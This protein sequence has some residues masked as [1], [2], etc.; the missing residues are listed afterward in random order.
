V[1]ELLR[2]ELGIDPGERLTALHRNILHTELATGRALAGAQVGRP[3]P[4]EEPPPATGHPDTDN[5][6][7]ENWRHLCQ[8]P[9]NVTTFVGRGRLMGEIAAVMTAG[10]RTVPVATL[11]GPPG[12][13][14][15][16]LAIR[17]AHQLSDHFPDGQLYARMSGTREG[18]RDPGDVLA[19]F[20]QTFGVSATLIPEGTEAKAALF[21][22]TISGRRVLLVLDD[23]LDAEQVRPLLPGSSGSGAIVTS[24]DRL[25]SLTVLH[26]A[27]P[28]MV[29]MLTPP[30]ASGLLTLLLG[31]RRT[32]AEPEAVRDLARLCGGLPLALRIAAANLTFRSSERIRAYYEELE[33]GDTLQR[34]AVG[35]HEKISVKAAFQASYTTLT[36][37][38]RRLFRL[39]GRMPISDFSDET[40]LAVAGGS[41]PERELEELVS[42][43]LVDPYTTGRFRFHNLVRL[44]AIDR[45]RAQDEDEKAAAGVVRLIS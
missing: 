36:P 31:E 26:D 18:R 11:T 38:A 42:T 5:P 28:L 23:V 10:C 8:L 13:G 15:S 14:K 7:A 16:A 22:A 24:R 12:A 21:R 25:P 4:D 1:A 43:H 40:A 41:E 37:R 3:A 29:G 45:A 39:L 9:A 17:S 44:Y 30:E 34:L 19:E 33:T 20:L 32:A 27:K 6:F 2:D 35:G